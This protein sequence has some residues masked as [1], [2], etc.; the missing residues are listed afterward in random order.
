M[1]HKTHYDTVSKAI[2]ALRKQGYTIVAPNYSVAGKT[3][4][5]FPDCILDLYEAIEWTKNNASLYGLDTTN[6]GLLGE[7]AGAH[8]AMMIAFSDSTLKPEKY[9]KTKF[10]YLIDVY[11]PNDLMDLY[12]A[13]TVEKVDHSIKR[14]SRIFGS[15]FDIRE[16]VFG[17]DPL[18][19]SVRAKELL[20]N[21]SPI[22]IVGQNEIPV[23]IIHGESDRIVPVQQSMTLKQKLDGLGIS[24]EIHLL[25]GM[26]HNFLFSSE[27]QRDSTQL[28]VAD[29]V[30][31]CY[32][33]PS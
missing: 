21:F 32:R 14:V 19:D 27:Q 1:Q 25:R 33:R 11:G 10:N 12:H 29:F 7:S 4:N 17:F 13:E 28:W 20:Y 8:I 9:E 16:Y 3:E 22:N 23:L 24:N 31:R 2:E 30:M 26:D 6:M 18:Q 5:V 15:E